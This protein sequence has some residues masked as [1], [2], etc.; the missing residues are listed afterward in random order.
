[1]QDGPKTSQ[2]ARVLSRRAL[3]LSGGGAKG[4]Y[5]AGAIT[6]L[7]AHGAPFDIIVGTSVGAINASLVAQN[8]VAALETLWKTVAAQNLIQPLPMVAHAETFLDAFSQWQKLPAEAKIGQIPRLVMLWMQ[9]G[10]KT[11]LLSLLGAFD[12]API[13]T[14]LNRFADFNALRRT[15]I[16][17]ATNVSTR[18]PTAF[19]W[20]APSLSSNLTAFRAAV[21]VPTEAISPANYGD[22]LQ[23][24]ASIPGAFNPMQMN[25]GGPPPLL[26]VDGGVSNNTPISLAIAAGADEVTVILLEPA[27]NPEPSPPPRNLVDVAYACYDVMQQKILED[28]FKLAGFTNAMLAVAT[29]SPAV[30]KRLAGKRIVG[31]ECVRPQ[32]ALPIT[33]LDFADQ[34]KIDAAFAQGVAEGQHPQAF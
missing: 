18:T 28:D 2:K 34:S 21:G 31:L 7:C 5:E 4:A 3:V 23:A 22:A 33:V 9:M 6:S 14:L 13:A 11:P 17:T 32:T 12:G 1:L 20:F 15:L 16:V 26:F 27:S 30:Q 29:P 19:F 8:S 25:L 10:S 24:S